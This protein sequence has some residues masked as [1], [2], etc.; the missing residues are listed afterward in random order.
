MDLG[1]RG[2]KALVTGGTKGIGRAIAE[3]LAAE[4]AAVALCARN[5]AEV[6]DTVAHLRGLGVPATGSAVDVTDAA[7]AEGMGGG[8]RERAGRAGHR[9]PQ[10]Q[11]AGDQQ[12]RGR[13]ARRV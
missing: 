12:R 6:A 5:A 7:A 11:R 13:L 9:H 2:R 10:R 3:H 1:L 4:G 8:G